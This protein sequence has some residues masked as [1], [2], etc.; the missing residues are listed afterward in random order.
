MGETQ[1]LAIA[2]A[3]VDVGACSGPEVVPTKCCTLLTQDALG[4]KTW[5]QILPGTVNM[6]YPFADDPLER[7]RIAS[8]RTPFGTE[9]LE[10]EA[11]SFATFTMTTVLE[12]DIA[13]FVDQLF[14]EVL[15][16]DDAGYEVQAMIE[17]LDP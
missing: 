13:Y 12:A 14:V 8:V 10:W 11:S 9:L 16:C 15:G 7:L 1:R 3:A 2:R 5:I 4:A 6:T 17:M